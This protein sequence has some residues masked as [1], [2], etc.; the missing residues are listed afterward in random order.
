[1]GHAVLHSRPHTSRTTH[2]A[3]RTT[4]PRHSS[5]NR[6]ASTGPPPFRSLRRAA[7]RFTAAHSRVCGS[8]RAAHNSRLHNSRVAPTRILRR[9]ATPR[10]SF[11]AQPPSQPSFHSRHRVALRFTAAH[12]RVWAKACNLR[13]LNPQQPTHQ[14]PHSLR[15][16]AP[17]HSSETEPPHSLRFNNSAAQPPPHP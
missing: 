13:K 15:L 8:N 5:D 7:H 4:T 12:S 3:Q 6:T 17:T 14:Q 9:T 1:M 16:A 10:H 2:N 11:V